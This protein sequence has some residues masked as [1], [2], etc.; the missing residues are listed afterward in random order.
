MT[1]VARYWPW[2][3]VVIGFVL[4]I[5]TFGMSY[6]FDITVDNLNSN[7][8]VFRFVKPLLANPKWTKEV[9]E[10]SSFSVYVKRSGTWDFK[11]PLWEF[12]LEPGVALEIK[13]IR[14]GVVPEGF[15]ETTKAQPLLFGEIYMVGGSAAG[16]HG[17]N[18]E[19]ILTENR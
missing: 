6:M 14:Y 1:R 12:S 11:H 13:E 7:Q 16:G 3:L 5:T 4:P 9:I 2:R 8:P 17:R 18:Q 15:T 10:L 19:F